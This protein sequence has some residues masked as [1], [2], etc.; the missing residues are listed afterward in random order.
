MGRLID[1]IKRNKLS[2]LLILISIYLLGK[3]G[4]SS[5]LGYNIAIPNPK[6]YDSN[7]RIGT[8]PMAGGPANESSEHL[9]NL[10][11]AW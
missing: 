7:R 1:W 10:Q 5:F 2:T 9:R 8:L 4:F 11:T 3:T 6:S